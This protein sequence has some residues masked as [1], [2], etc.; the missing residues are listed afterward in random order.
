MSW[1][2]KRKSTGGKKQSS[3][4]AGEDDIAT[5]PLA[6]TGLRRVAVRR[7]KGKCYVDLREMY[8]DAAGELKPTAKG[9]MLTADQF[10]MLQAH[11]GA[12]AS[13]LASA[14]GPE[15]ASAE[16]AD[17]PVASASSSSSSSALAP[18]SGDSAAAAEPKPDH[19][20]ARTEAE[21]SDE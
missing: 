4:G 17:D 20:R 13:A 15:S 7:F 14:E 21:S 12:I 19:K 11:M 5:F 18:S 16:D 3:D 10:K 6:S 1:R 2:G 8:T 9:L